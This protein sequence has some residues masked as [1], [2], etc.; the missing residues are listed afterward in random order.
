M[1]YLLS[2][3]CSVL[4]ITPALLYVYFQTLN[5]IF[6]IGIIPHAPVFQHQLYCISFSINVVYYNYIGETGWCMAPLFLCI[7]QMAQSHRLIPCS[8]SKTGI[9]MSENWL[10]RVWLE[11]ACSVPLYHFGSL[12]SV[13]TFLY[14]WSVYRIYLYSLFE[15]YLV[16]YH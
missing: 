13:P 12:K 15:I 1:F 16:F 3:I 9:H 7:C 2:H 4:I 8:E 6:L 11:A 14:I 10:K 5:L